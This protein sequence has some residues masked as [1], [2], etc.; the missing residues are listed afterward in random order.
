MRGEMKGSKNC[1]DCEYFAHS[2]ISICHME[3][4]VYIPYATYVYTG[5]D[6]GLCN[7]MRLKIWFGK[8]RI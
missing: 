3:L 5:F 1:K 8:V 4:D 2:F 7:K 6:C